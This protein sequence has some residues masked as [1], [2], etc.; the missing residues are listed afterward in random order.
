MNS[1]IRERQ[2]AAIN[3]DIVTES[4]SDDPD[5]IQRAMTPFDPSLIQKRC[6][7]MRR[8]ANRL[9]AKRVVE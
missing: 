1:E 5:R 2:A 9:K 6:V 3:R 8:R 4:E 7:S